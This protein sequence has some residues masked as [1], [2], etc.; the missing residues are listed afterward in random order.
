MEKFIDPFDWEAIPEQCGE[1]GMLMIVSTFTARIMVARIALA[2]GAARG[3]PDF[4]PSKE[5]EGPKWNNTWSSLLI[6]ALSDS[7]T[8]M[9]ACSGCMRKFIKEAATLHNR[10][11]AFAAEE[12]A[13]LTSESNNG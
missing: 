8:P 10:Y 4:A 11:T 3:N 2:L 7:D 12:N 5:C 6:C 13:R 1:A 9:L